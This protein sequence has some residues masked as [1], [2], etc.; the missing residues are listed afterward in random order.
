MRLVFMS[1]PASLACCSV[2][3]TLATCGWQ[4]VAP[5]T[6][7]GSRGCVGAPAIVSA[8]TT[9]SSWALWASAEISCTKLAKGPID[10]RAELPGTEGLLET[11][12]AQGKV[13]FPVE[14]TL[15]DADG[16]TVATATVQWHV[17]L[18]A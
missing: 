14:V 6:R 11:L 10:A 12:D 18:S 7:F 13:S 2:S 4:K 9:P 5:A 3:P 17:R 8:A 15:T 1:L 16:H